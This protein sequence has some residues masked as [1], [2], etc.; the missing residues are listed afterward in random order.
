MV[1]ELQD[2]DL[3][4]RLGPSLRRIFLHSDRSFFATVKS[5]LRNLTHLELS[6]T[7]DDHRQETSAFES[8][9]CHG[10]H[11]ESLRVKGYVVKRHSVSFR[12]HPD[13]LPDLRHF[14]VHITAD[15]IRD[16]DLF[17]AILDFLR[18]RPQLESLE[19][20][21][22]FCHPGATPDNSVVSSP[23]WDILSEFPH[24][25]KL[26]ITIPHDKSSITEVIPSTVQTLI[27]SSKYMTYSLEDAIP[28]VRPSSYYAYQC[29]T[30][31]VG[32]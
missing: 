5:V 16:E 21:S 32:R 31:F 2:G 19:L 12:N 25:R 17:P 10:I 30:V 9:L 13:A 8:I 23:C 26:A 18:N 24:I 28:G 22:P 27:L 3:F 15:G 20:I 1:P 11:L 6:G 4:R 29:L 14:G 7:W